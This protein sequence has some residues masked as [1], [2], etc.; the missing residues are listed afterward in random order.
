[1]RNYCF[2]FCIAGQPNRCSRVSSFTIVRKFIIKYDHKRFLV[3]NNKHSCFS[4]GI[5]VQDPTPAYKE[6]AS[7]VC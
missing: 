6:S 4:R 1:M 3:S 5:P 7:Q 2:L